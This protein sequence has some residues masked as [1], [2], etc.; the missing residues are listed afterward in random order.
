[1]NFLSDNQS[2]VFPEIINYLQYI[3]KNS[4]DSYGNDPIT[5]KAQKIVSDFFDKKVQIRYVSS[6]T[7][8]NSISLASI[9]PPY[10]GIICSDSSHLYSDECG[11][12]EFF[13]GGAKLIQIP[14]S[15]GLITAENL[16]NKINSFGLHGIHEIKL[17][18]LSLTQL[19][20][21]GTVY[22]IDE[23]TKASNMLI[24]VIFVNV[25]NLFI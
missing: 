10:G 14:T 12:P 8:S 18:A 7:A 1:M 6:G 17:S 16:K 5:K 24:V 23:L 22:E 11:A 21:L 15:N 4:L 20:E 19:S 9:C 13:T 2:T 25:I 3:N